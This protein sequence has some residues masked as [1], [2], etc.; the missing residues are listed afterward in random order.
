MKT[1]LRSVILL[2]ALALVSACEDDP[3]VPEQID[4]LKLMP[5][6]SR[7]AVLNNIEYAYNK[8]NPN[9]YDALL[10]DAFT[11]FLAAGDVG[12]SIPEQWDRADEFQV[13]QSLFISNIQ[14]IA[15]GPECRSINVDIAFEDGVEWQ[16]VMPE[17]FPGETWY[18]ATVYYT[19]TFEMEPATTYIAQ[20]G[21]EAQFTVREVA[22]GS[23]T[24]W[25]LV[26]WRDLG[27]T[28]L[29]SS[30]QDA[31]TSASTWGSVKALYK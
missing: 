9:A 6:T 19:F 5:L 24:E 11:F 28:L 2:L 25:Q 17:G 21:A 23:G 30:R 27:Y 10:D 14:P 18:T 13:T 3:A 4:P 29:T 20:P 15:T 1:I 26:E 16:A 31:S 7:V 8:R 22:A 12:G